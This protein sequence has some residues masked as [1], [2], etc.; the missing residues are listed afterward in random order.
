MPLV[1]LENK[2]PMKHHGVRFDDARWNKV[3]T[4]G[5]KHGGV[6]ASAVLRMMVDYY[7]DKNKKRKG[8]K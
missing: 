7:F 6:S 8:K 5:K 4:E 3:K 2:K 1:T